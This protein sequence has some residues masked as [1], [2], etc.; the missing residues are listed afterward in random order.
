LLWSSGIFWGV[1]AFFIHSFVDFDFYVPNLLFSAFFLIGVFMAV[2]ARKREYTVSKKSGLRLAYCV[3]GLIIFS[4]LVYNQIC[5]INYL[6]TAENVKNLISGKKLDRA[7][8][9]IG[10][11]LKTVRFNSGVHFDSGR[12]NEIM[13]FSEKK[14]EYLPLAVYEYSLATSF[15]PQRPGYHFRL[16]MMYWALR[17]EPAFFKKA[18]SEFKLAHKAYPTKKEYRE[19]LEQIQGKAFGD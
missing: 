3:F 19:F 18:V 2:N 13:A 14:K 9:E 11:L 7:E 5:Y 17:D 16:G 6:W 4:I 12:L 1:L 10:R 8:Q 15:N